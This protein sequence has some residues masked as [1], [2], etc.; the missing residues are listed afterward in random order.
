MTS[1]PTAQACQ[2]EYRALKHIKEAL[3]VTLRWQA[4]R[5]GLSRKLASVMFIIRALQRHLEHQLELEEQ[6]GYLQTIGNEK[7]SLVNEAEQLLS[8]HEAFRAS[9]HDILPEIEGLN[10]SDETR[11]NVLCDEVADLLRRIDEHDQREADLLQE[12]YLRDEGGEG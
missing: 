5:V 2:D 11:F 12:V 8:E 9:L 3:A 10:S 1:D 7:P 6:G 4:P